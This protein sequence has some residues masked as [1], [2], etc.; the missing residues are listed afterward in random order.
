MKLYA[1]H[2]EMHQAYPIKVLKQ[3]GGREVLGKGTSV[4]RYIFGNSWNIS[5]PKSRR[6]RDC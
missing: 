1:Y 5:H 2:E 6:R 4:E 3:A